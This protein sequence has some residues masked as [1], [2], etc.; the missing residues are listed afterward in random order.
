M[1]VLLAL[2]V[3]AVWGATDTV[4]E[5]GVKRAATAQHALGHWKSLLQSPLFVL[6]QAANWAA[7]AA[8]AALLGSAQLHTLGPLANAASLATSALAGQLFGAPQQLRL[9]LP[10]LACVAAG[11]VLC[12]E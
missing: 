6:A 3:G 12:A 10:D 7:S 8:L 9:L 2:A 1:S 5:I 11:V 4:S